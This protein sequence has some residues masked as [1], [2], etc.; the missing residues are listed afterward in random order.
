M[1]HLHPV[2]QTD[3]DGDPLSDIDD[4]IYGGLDDERHSERVPILA[5]LIGDTTASD[6]DR[7]LACLTL[8]TWGEPSGYLAL[9]SAATSL[10]PWADVS[11]DRHF[12]VNDT[13]GHFLTALD[14]SAEISNEKG[15][16]QLRTLALRAL[17]Q[18]ADREYFGGK[19]GYLP[20]P[21]DASDVLEVIS[22]T[23]QRGIS[24]LESG[25][26]LHFDLPTQLVDLASSVTSVNEERAVDIATRVLQITAGDRA[27]KHAVFIVAWSRRRREIIR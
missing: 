13:F 15:T 3:F 20:K 6:Y 10:P 21:S 27:I 16:Q 11:M 24:R 17:I 4:L 8:T 9:E 18:A 7:Y 23:A 1:N 25:G 14:D 2:F 26:N 22:E 5:E 12:S 19:I